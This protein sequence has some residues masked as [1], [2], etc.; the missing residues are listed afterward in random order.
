[1]PTVR[2]CHLVG[3]VPLPSTEDVLRQCTAGMPNRLKRIP[4][5]ETGARNMF[6]MFQASVFSPVPEMST[7]FQMNSKIPARDYTAA[8]VDEGIRKL[9]AAGP[10][11]T[12]YDTAAIESYAVFQKMKAEGVVHGTTKFQACIP[13]VASVLAPFV[14]AAFQ[15]KVEP[16]YEEALFRA[17]RRIQ[18]AIPH[19]ELAIQ[20]DL[21]AD[22]AYWE[23]YELFQ[24]WF[25]EG[26]L[27]KIRTYCVDY[28]VRMIGQVD[29][30]VEVGLHNCYGDMD[31]RHFMEPTSLAALVERSR[32]IY[33]QTPHPISFIHFPVPKSAADNLQS[34]L[35]PLKDLIPTF[36]EHN[37]ELYLGVVH[38]NNLD[39]TRK[40]VAA[41]GEVLGDFPFGVAT[42]CGWG[43]TAA[44]E[45]ESILSISAEVSEP[46]L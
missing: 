37:T 23:G 27:E 32:R 15:A 31:H 3:S 25:G 30:D 28:V 14:Q 9:Q 41:A 45:I 16:I 12:G 1:M 6:T 29:G 40:M 18:D 8:D 44:G 34:F 33:E 21:A 17:I 2:G 26:D 19:D 5:G 7:L 43:R 36:K 20:I 11:E 13:T 42:E 35:A 24:P 22:T 39:L 4:D 46:I 10:V 38:E